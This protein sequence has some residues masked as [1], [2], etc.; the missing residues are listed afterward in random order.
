VQTFT[1]GLLLPDVSLAQTLVVAVGSTFTAQR[2]LTITTGDADRTLTLTGNASIGGTSSGTNTGD[3]TITLTGDVTG[4]GTGSFAATI[5]N[6]AVTYAKM[7]NVSATSRVLGR[8][9][10]AAGDTEECTLSEVLDMIG[11]AAQGDILYRGAATWAR[12]AAGTSGQILQSGGA[13]GNPSWTTATASKLVQRVYTSF[14]GDY[15]TTST[16]PIDDTIPQSG[17]GTELGTLSIT[18]TSTSN[19]LLITAVFPMTGISVGTNY[20]CVALF[21]DS[22]ADAINATTASIAATT[23]NVPMSLLHVEQCTSTSSQTFKIRYGPNS[24]TGYLNRRGSGGTLGSTM[25]VA[26]LVIEEWE[27]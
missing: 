2:T 25:P 13:G 12:L 27:P 8:K 7:Q 19:Y 16:I 3:Q 17:E 26:Y 24:G 10:A 1:G 11:S 18:P 14:A 4:S 20:L 6:D 15:S 22:G 21:K 9:T 5:A 23:S